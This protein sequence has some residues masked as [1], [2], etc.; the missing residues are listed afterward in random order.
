MPIH[1]NSLRSRVKV[2]SLRRNIAISPTLQRSIH[3]HCPVTPT[4]QVECDIRDRR[5]DISISVIRFDEFSWLNA[6]T[7]NLVATS[8]T[9]V[10]RGL[11][12]FD[13]GTNDFFWRCYNSSREIKFI[14]GK[15]KKKFFF[16]IAIEIVDQKRKNRIFGILKSWL[17]SYWNRVKH[18]STY[19]RKNF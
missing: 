1:P 5:V 15:K 6:W 17:I 14:H 19:L 11:M 13:N 18:F 9:N 16:V 10:K 7:D 12:M 8:V 3:G 2:P 4:I